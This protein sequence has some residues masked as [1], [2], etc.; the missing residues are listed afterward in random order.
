MTETVLL[1]LALR[2][3]QDVFTLRQRGREAATALG[4]EH[5][6][7]IRLAT[8]LSD[9]GRVLLARAPAVEVVFRVCRHPDR[10]RIDLAVDGSVERG[11]LQ[12]AGRLVDGLEV[13]EH[14]KRTV[15]MLSRRLPVTGALTE[16]RVDELRRA[17]GMTAVASPLDELA[18][19]NEHLLAALEDVRRQRDRLTVLNDE[20]EE[21]NRGVMALYHQLNSEL[22]ET[23]RGVVALYAELDEK[24]SQLRAASEAKT[25]FLANV[26]HELRAPVTSVIGLIR[27]LSDP[28]S[29]PLTPA[30]QEQI[31]LMRGSTS[32]LLT[33]VNDLLDL[34]KAE[35]GR[36]QPDWQTVS[37]DRLFRQLRGTVRAILTN[38]DVELIVDEPGEDAWIESDE[39]LLSQVLRNL[40]HNAVKFTEHGHV[41]LHVR[42]DERNWM[43]TVADTGSGIP[44]D[45]QER[46]F[47]EFVQLPSRHKVLGTGLG[48]PYA[49][50][51]T[52]ILGGSMDLDSQPG[53]GSE[54]TVTLPLVRQA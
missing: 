4:L 35:S 33:L 20:L 28:S 19:Q 42:S 24:S 11:P 23:N 32:D 41:A 14:G 9:V 29:D 37:L 10:L 12:P 40:L 49:R 8:A 30:Q 47:E 17:L 7:Q 44:A 46:I 15:V 18:T 27:M 1:Q 39:A 34:A 25:R 38:P 48:L 6:D 43:F 53:R 54:F 21:T 51:L 45:E 13:V 52:G 16:L 50:R 26:S 22:E 2:R 3:E 5:Q 31:E 36:L